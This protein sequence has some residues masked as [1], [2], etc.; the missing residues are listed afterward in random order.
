MG[1]RLRV[2]VV[3]VGRL[4]SIHARIYAEL[5]TA[6]LVAVADADPARAAEVA[7]KHGCRAVGDW[8]ALLGEVDAVSVAVP[9]TA[10]AE[11]GCAFLE[12][13]IAVLVEK[14]MAASLAEADRLLEASRRRGVALQVGHVERFNPAVMASEKVV[15]TPLFI[16]VHRLSPFAFRSSD[17]DVILDLM[18]H[19]LDIIRHLVRSPLRKAEAVGVP[20]LSGSFD[21]V[22]ARLEFENGCVA[23]VTASRVSAKRMR[24]IRVFSREGYLSLDYGDRR[25]L[26]FRPSE[27]V[28]EGRVNPSRMPEAAQRDPLQYFLENLV[29]VEEISFSEHEPLKKEIEEF[30]DCVR[31]GRAPAV[32]GEDGKAAM[33]L[34]EAVRGAAEAHLRSV[35]GRGMILGEKP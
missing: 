24:K 32:P 21:I 18:I 7:A 35:R 27:A 3:G 23:N 22:N 29:Q 8:R 15:G 2:G 14:P 26:L 20:L 30:V 25:A 31:A 13:G 17:I 28:R 11:V 12:A 6:S 33:E 16:E 5:G 34:A 19:D 4:G 10:H 1:G 9:T